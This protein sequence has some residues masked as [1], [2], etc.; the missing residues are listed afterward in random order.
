MKE[1][2]R[3]IKLKKRKTLNNRFVYLHIL[4]NFKRFNFTPKRIYFHD[5]SNVNSLYA[6]LY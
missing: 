5:Y 2:Y 6:L 4:E 1:T 3:I